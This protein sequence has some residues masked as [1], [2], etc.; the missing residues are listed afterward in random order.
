M[1]R[2][3]LVVRKP[4]GALGPLGRGRGSGCPRTLPRLRHVDT[5]QGLGA[6]GARLTAFQ[7]QRGHFS[8]FFFFHFSAF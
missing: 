2:A 1:G 7:P 4:L 8:A 5:A 6:S 3:D